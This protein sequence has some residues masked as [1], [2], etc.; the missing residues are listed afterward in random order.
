M[1]FNALLA[2]VAS[3]GLAVATPTPDAAA[4]AVP[5]VHGGLNSDVVLHT[6]SGCGSIGP[7]GP[8]H[9]IWWITVSCNPGAKM[10]CQATDVTGCLPGNPKDIGSMEVDDPNDTFNIARGSHT[11]SVDF[12]CPSGG[13]V[14]CQ[15]NFNDNNDGPN[16]SLRV[17]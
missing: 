11:N 17:F 5:T 12:V 6:Q 10:T 3:I 14:R 16:Y 8:G 9:F 15:A 7:L 13:A 2:L 4:A 1:R